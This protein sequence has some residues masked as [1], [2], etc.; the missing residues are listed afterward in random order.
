MALSIFLTD[1]ATDIITAV[2]EK[3]TIIA[4]LGL[5]LNYFMK[6]L[7]TVQKMREEDKKESDR[8]F[9]EMFER[10]FSVEKQNIEAITKQSDTNLRL[11]DAIN[12][13]IDRIER[14]KH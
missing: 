2:A 4:V 9:E 8:K 12:D 13:L 6:E 1:L 5:F 7:K 11:T 10:Q 14:I 3:L